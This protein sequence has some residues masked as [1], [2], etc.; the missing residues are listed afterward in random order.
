[1]LRIDVLAGITL[2]A[3]LVPA[4]IGDSSLAGLPPEA[5][6]YACMFSGLVF[7]WLCGSRHTVITVTSAISLLLGTSLGELAGGDQTRFA[8][9]ASCTALLVA[10]LALGS[11]LIRA[12]ELVNFVSE[13]VLVGFKVGVALTLAST[14]LPKLLGISSGHGGFWSNGRHLIEHLPETNWTALTVGLAALGVLV[15]GKLFLKN[16]PVALFVV[17]GAIIAGGAMGLR[18]RG[19]KM[20]GEVPSGLPAMGLP[21]V[22]WEDLNELLP[23]AMAC[24]LLGAVE[25]AAI[26]RMFASKHGGRLNANREL[27]GLAGG[28]LAAGLGQGFPVSGGMSQSLVNESA[29]ARTPASGLIAAGL[30]GIVII[31]FS[32]MLRNLPQPVLAAIVLMAVAGLVKVHTLVHLW[33]TDRTELLIAAAALMGVL[34]SG[35]LR[36]VL[37]GAVISMLLLIRRAARPHVGFLGRIPGSRRYSDLDRHSDNEEINGV[38]IFRPEGSLVYFNADHVRDVVLRRATSPL[39]APHTVI[40]DLS[41]SPLVDLAGAEMLKGLADE[42]RAKGTRLRVVEAR[43]RV[44]DRLRKLEIEESVGQIDRHTSVADAVDAA[45]GNGSDDGPG[46]PNSSER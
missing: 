37:I 19:V 14:Q 36:G 18:E 25:T 12:G 10:A 17:V 32:G 27:L 29:G 38:L 13:T 22:A 9:L 45:I 46:A 33:K 28:N 16:K 15:L 6:L 1:M 11:W 3:Y 44:R 8:A 35:L 5:G 20:L 42:L 30:L 2:A 43:S 21:A 23:L 24:F 39:P 34:A 41:A 7:G 4:G 40:C 31:F 26:G